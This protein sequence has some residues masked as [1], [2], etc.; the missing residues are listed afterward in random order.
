LLAASGS[1]LK[2]AHLGCKFRSQGDGTCGENKCD[3]GAGQQ[4]SKVAPNMEIGLEGPGRM[5]AKST[6]ANNS[7]RISESIQAAAAR[8]PVTKN[9][10][11]TSPGRRHDQNRG[12]SAARVVLTPAEARARYEQ[13]GWR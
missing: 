7:R 1:I 12:R 13:I 9:P 8:V 5:T 4:R 3:A 6:A 11:R 2:I 10:R